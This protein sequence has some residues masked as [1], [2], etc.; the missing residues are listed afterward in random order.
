MRI[1]VEIIQRLTEVP[2]VTGARVLAFGCDQ[3]IPEIL[4]RR[5][6]PPPSEVTRLS[7]FLR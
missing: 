4:E 3:G 5:G 1:C 6:R 7:S 2:G